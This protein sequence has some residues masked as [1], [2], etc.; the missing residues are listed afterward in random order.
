M[1]IGEFQKK[2]KHIRNKGFRV[3]EDKLVN[4]FSSVSEIEI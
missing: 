4:L 2:L 1:K 3:K